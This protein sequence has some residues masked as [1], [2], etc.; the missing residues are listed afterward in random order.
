MIQGALLAMLF[1]SGCIEVTAPVIRAR[2]LKP[3]IP[4]FAPIDDSIEIGYAPLPGATRWLHR[5]SLTA[6]GLRHGAPIHA[7]E[8][9]CVVRRTRTLGKEEL[10]DAVRSE[11]QRSAPG[12]AV[13]IEILDHMRL[14]VPDGE[15]AFSAR[16]LHFTGDGA[17]IWKGRIQFDRNRSFPVWVRARVQ[18]DG[19][20]FTP[21]RGPEPAG[22]NQAEPVAANK[23][24]V[25][26]VASES[27]V[28]RIVIEALALRSGRVGDLIEVETRP[29]GHRLRARLTAPGQ[30]RIVTE[31]KSNE[32]DRSGARLRGAAWLRQGQRDAGETKSP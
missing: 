19:R 9:V 25:I 15:I 13:A 21:K 31:E 24:D 1:A 22:S 5:A 4:G 20:P 8:D 30:A 14:P 3:A 18:L 7:A 32:V 26:R 10:E 23:G 17:G 11:V 16:D 29:G 27:G 2:D 6:F 12:S 28:V